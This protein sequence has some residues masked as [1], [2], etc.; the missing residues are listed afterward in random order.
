M[1]DD[2]GRLLGGTA[3]AVAVALLAYRRRSLAPS[4][5]IAAVPVGATVVWGLGWWAGF[6]LVLFFVSSS[7]LSRLQAPRPAADTIA[8]RGS[9]RDAVQVLANG[10]VPALAALLA[11]LAPEAAQP[12]LFAAFAGSVAAATADTWATELGRFSP[13]P[14]R[15]VVGGRLVPPGTSGGVTLVGTGA[16]LAGAALIAA[17]TTA[18]VAADWAVGSWRAAFLGTA[19]AGAVGSLLDSVLGATVQAAYRCPVCAEPTEHRRHRCGSPTRLVRGHAA[20]TND[21]VNA[22]A[23]ATGALLGALLAALL[24]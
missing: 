19:V 13:G 6:V 7:A 11:A 22:A 9:R 3:A 17:A 23:V 14:P 4:G 5:A 1:T 18:G 20:V 16:A 24:G 15:L 10:G 21:A 12:L 8:V 2:L